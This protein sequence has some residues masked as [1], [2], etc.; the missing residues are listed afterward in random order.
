MDLNDEGM[1]DHLT[2]A[3]EPNFDT[4]Y[5]I[6]EIMQQR[7]LSA[8]DTGSGVTNTSLTGSQN[9]SHAAEQSSRNLIIAA[10]PKSTSAY[11]LVDYSFFS[12]TIPTHTSQHQSIVVFTY[13]FFV[14]K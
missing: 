11:V 3:T 2:N 9:I 4:S 14:A 12:P 13:I 7:S 1:L 8:F 10:L 6:G 5:S